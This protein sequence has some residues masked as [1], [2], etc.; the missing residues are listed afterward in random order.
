MA[1]LLGAEEITLA[2]PTKEVF[3]G[4][5][6]GINEGDRIGVVGANGDGKS[7]LLK[8]LAKRLDVDSGRV[9][10]RGGIRIGLLDQADVLDGSLTIGALSNYTST[11]AFSITGALA[12][13]GAAVTLALPAG[14]IS[15]GTYKLISYGSTSATDA[16]FTV[17]GPVI[18]ARQFGGLTKD[19]TNK[20][21]LYTVGGDSPV[22][23]GANSNVFSG[24]NN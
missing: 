7:T 20:L 19:D 3:S 11:A 18:G 24:G 16:N 22:W 17:T 12:V 21:F 15:N 5:T 6:I 13:N 4:V 1:H 9:T 8:V 2:F 10:H 23:T 14:L